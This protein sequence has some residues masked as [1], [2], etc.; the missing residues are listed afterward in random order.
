MTTSIKTTPAAINIRRRIRED[1][2]WF[3][4]TRCRG[5]GGQNVNKVSSGVTL[6]FDLHGTDSLT[7]AEKRRVRTR[8]HTRVTRDG[9]LY[10]VSMHHR[11]QRA[12]RQAA[13]ERFY[14]L[15]AAALYR[16]RAR[17]PTVPSQRAHE[18]RLHEKRIRG[19]HKL[20]RGPPARNNSDH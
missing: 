14:E 19:G 9:H 4:F 6:R 8:L 11:T 12:N 5:P 3:T 10:I 16:P 7:E 1:E 18:R 20:L 2:L 15:L 13:I 17:K